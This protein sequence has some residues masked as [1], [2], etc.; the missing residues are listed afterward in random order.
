M[1]VA[2]RACALALILS[3][4]PG[5]GED[6]AVGPKPAEI[7]GL[8][9]AT[10]DEY[11]SKSN[12]ALSVNRIAPDSIA[13]CAINS[14]KSYVFILRRAGHAPDTTDGTWRL[15]GDQFMVNPYDRPQTTWVWDASLTSNTLTLTGADVWY[16]FNGDAQY[17]VEEEADNNMVLVR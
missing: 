4:L 11:V 1:S 3:L 5:C 2:L 8:W 14:D 7:T 6:K 15:D 16:D 12:P 9:S 17:Q 13:T 10:K